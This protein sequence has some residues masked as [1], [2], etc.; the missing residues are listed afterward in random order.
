MASGALAVRPG[1]G[2]TADLGVTRMRIL[3]AGKMTGRAFTVAEF[4][5]AE[6]AW[7]IPHVHKHME[8]SFFVLE[9]NFTFTVGNENIKAGRGMYVLVPRGTPHT[10]AAAEGGGRVLT[11]MVPGGLEAMFLEL[12]RMPPDSLR[13]PAARRAVSA[14]YDSV[15]VQ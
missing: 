7:T 8:E 6:G 12:A 13:D 10:L 14:K 4:A 1:E 11:L 5:G 2:Q 3:A 15:P 9:G